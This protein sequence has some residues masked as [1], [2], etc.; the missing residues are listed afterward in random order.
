MAADT[1]K[2]FNILTNPSS[3]IDIYNFLILEKMFMDFEIHSNSLYHLFQ[4][5]FLHKMVVMFFN[6]C[7]ILFVYFIFQIVIKL[8]V[9]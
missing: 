3:H 8:L 4:N 9:I 5:S 2:S 1:Y 6:L 7:F